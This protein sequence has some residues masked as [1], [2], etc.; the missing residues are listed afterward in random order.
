MLLEFSCSNHKSIRKD[1]LFSALA[2]TDTTKIE[3]TKE[4]G[5][6]RVLKSAV[7]YGANGSGKSN[8]LDAISFVRSAERRVGRECRSRWSP[9]H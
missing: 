6:Y 2:G 7:I 4:F 5:K 8:F 9:Y 1:V 3:D